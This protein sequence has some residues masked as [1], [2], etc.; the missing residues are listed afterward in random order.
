MDVCVCCVMSWFHHRGG[1][2]VQSV[3]DALTRVAVP[4]LIELM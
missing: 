2:A 3:L 1:T 4:G